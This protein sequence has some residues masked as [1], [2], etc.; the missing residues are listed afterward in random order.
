MKN[1]GAMIM[2]TKSNNQSFSYNQMGNNDFNTG[3]STN[4]RNGI[5]LDQTSHDFQN[6]MKILN[7]GPIVLHPT[8]RVQP[9]QNQF[10]SASARVSPLRDNIKLNENAD[11]NSLQDKILSFE[12]QNQTSQLQKLKQES[13]RYKFDGPSHNRLNSIS[14]LNSK[15]ILI[16]ET[17]LRS[18]ELRDQQLQSSPEIKKILKS[19]TSS[20]RATSNG[21]KARNNHSSLT[22]VGGKRQMGLN[23]SPTGKMQ[24]LEQ[25][26]VGIYDPSEEAYDLSKLNKVIMD[27]DDDAGGAIMKKL[28]RIHYRYVMEINDN[29][30]IDISGQMVEANLKK[31]APRGQA[32]PLDE[33][34]I[35]KTVKKY[36]D[37]NNNLLSLFLNKNNIADFEEIA[38][39]GSDKQINN[40]CFKDNP[41]RKLDKKRVVEVSIEQLLFKEG[42]TQLSFYFVL[43][44]KIIL[45]SKELGAIGL[46]KMGEFVG[47]D[48]LFDT[49][50]PV[51][52]LTVQNLRCESAYSEGDTYLIEM[53]ISEWK[54]YKDVIVLM[55]LK[56]DFLNIDNVLKKGFQQKKVWR[57]YKS[58]YLK[59]YASASQLNFL[60]NENN[61]MLQNPLVQDTRQNYST[62]D[63]RIHNAHEKGKIHNYLPRIKTIKQIDSINL[64]I[65]SPLF[66]KACKNLGINPIECLSHPQESFQQKGVSQDV[67]D[68]RWKHYRSRLFQTIN[69]VLEER[70]RLAEKQNNQDP[71]LT[72]VD[73]NGSLNNTINNYN[74][75][76]SM[77]SVKGASNKLPLSLTRSHFSI[78]DLSLVTDLRLKDE[79]QKLERLKHK[80]HVMHQFISCY[81]NQILKQRDTERV[82]SEDYRRNSIESKLKKQEDY[83][84]QNFVST[85]KQLK[86]KKQMHEMKLQK[87]KHNQDIIR[88]E[89]MRTLEREENK[90]KKM[91]ELKTQKLDEIQRAQNMEIE[92][93]RKEYEEKRN[94]VLKQLEEKHRQEMMFCMSTMSKVESTLQEKQ[95]KHQQHLM[96]VQQEVSMKNLKWLE[97]KIKTQEDKEKKAEEERKVHEKT[98]QEIDKM[99][100]K[101]TKEAQKFLKQVQQQNQ[102]K[103]NNQSQLKKEEDYHWR[104]KCQMMDKKF[105]LAKQNVGQKKENQD[106]EFELRRE[107]RRIREEEIKKIQERKRMQSLNRKM[108]ILEKEAK[109][110][111]NLTNLRK[112]DDVLNHMKTTM[113]QQLQREKT[114]FLGQ[115]QKLAHDTS[116]NILKKQKDV[117]E[118][119]KQ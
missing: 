92:R 105:E 72:I 95:E 100:A 1:A 101:K 104:Q 18:I 16:N 34:Q 8:R 44:G 38:L 23:A 87:V 69:E 93:K 70:T 11:P 77:M 40:N 58:R 113:Y 4:D 111:D 116:I 91:F 106:H 73:N 54:K 57:Q 110:N 50:K 62:A 64:D 99:M 15:P 29:L 78:Q 3:N 56:K 12:Q 79:K 25:K 118:L 102:A 48:I 60:K 90:Q 10:I 36:T 88:K 52:M 27:E 63:G 55:G 32:R 14:T 2:N 20:M 37:P 68:L 46:I 67:I 13:M 112:S 98:Q 66:K 94:E 59:A 80:I 107:L 49:Q 108:E 47:E 5:A 61:K 81:T 89:Y 28:Y 7:P 51:S 53:T 76:K 117:Q 6:L 31:N 30:K 45:H 115:V 9:G 109:V 75:N 74:Q 19:E 33:V 96:E 71:N 26:L 43:F 86:Q 42:D 35:P 39:R 65:E 22:G 41:D 103:K 119:I 84:G 114:T 24:L 83:V 17:E 97:K 82:F 21:S 85:K